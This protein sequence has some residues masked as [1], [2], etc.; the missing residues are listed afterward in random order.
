MKLIEIVDPKP[1]PKLTN[2]IA[3]GIDLGTTFSLVAIHDKNGTK[4]I[5]DGNNA[6]LLRSAVQFINHQ[7]VVAS[8]RQH[9]SLSSFKR[10]IGK[11]TDDFAEDVIE[12]RKFVKTSNNK[13]KLKLDEQIISPIELSSVIL[14]SLIDRASNYLKQKITKAVITV[15][16]YFDDA[17]RAET[18]QAARLA[19]IEVIRIINEPTAAAL[20]YGLNK[21]KKGNY[22]VYDLGGGTFDISILKMSEGVLK[23]IATEGDTKLGGDDIDYLISQHIINQF[24]NSSSAK[25]KND[26]HALDQIISLAKIIKEKLSDVETTNISYS[27]K[28]EKIYLTFS[29][30]ELNSL[31]E[32]LINKTLTIVKRAIRASKLNSDEINGI[33]LVGGSTRIPLIRYKL[34]EY[35]NLK[36]FDDI[37]PDEA[38]AYGAAIQAYSLTN[39]TD[40]LLVD[41]VPLSFGIEVMGGVSD[42]IIERNSTIPLSVTKEFTTYANGQT[43]IKFHILQGEREIAKDCRSLA[44]FEISNL[45]AKPAGTI[46]VEVTFSVDANGILTVS[47]EDKTHNILKE[48]EIQ[49]SYGLTEKEINNMLEDSLKYAK[50]DVAAKLVT[51]KIIEAEQIISLV[52]QYLKEDF[53]LLNAEEVLIIKKKITLLKKS[54]KQKVRKDINLNLENLEQIITP[55]IE[56]RMNKYL[57][58]GLRGKKIDNI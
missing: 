13:I 50:E 9:P 12:V 38:V 39:Q 29:R 53:E 34:Q 26:N 42:K 44:K 37:N 55:F 46:K 7:W 17:A 36:I 24:S 57:K 14:K 52:E 54:I 35:F 1:K 21:K 45:P 43:G 41:V 48:I 40:H 27:Y 32:N 20:A 25:I 56:R 49:P 11:S 33:I 28:S 15:P 8:D 6:T 30:D 3:V 51:E 58:K 23:V 47:A 19:G 22:V 4:I 18:K 31:I 10:F 5:P 16:A 2:E